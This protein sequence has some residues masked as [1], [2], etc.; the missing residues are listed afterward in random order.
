MVQS[1]IFIK[2]K[3]SSKGLNMEKRNLYI[4][5]IEKLITQIKE[6]ELENIHIAANLIINSF[7]NDGW[8][9]V[10]GTG[11]SHMV[12]EEFF[13]RA[14]GL[15]KVR[16]IF[17]TNL[18]LHESAIKST[19]LERLTGYAEQILFNYK[20]NKNDTILIASNSGR[21]A[22]PIEVANI[23]RDIGTK[24]IVLTSM[25]HSKAVN[26][27]HVSNKK[28]YEFADVVIDNHGVYGDACINYLSTKV[29]STSTVINSMIVNCIISEIAQISESKHFNIEFFTSSNSNQGEQENAK[30]INKYKSLVRSL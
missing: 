30:L 6:H 16:P 3:T 27:R 5:E 23:A 19:S 26:S 7:I 28:L 2:E 15:A 4:N 29:A 18:M 14:G 25:N 21:N 12:A 24:V 8:L 1:Q 9:Y 13:Y 11:H 10:F 17:E 22:V 20:L